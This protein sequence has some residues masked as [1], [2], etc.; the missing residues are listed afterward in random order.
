MGRGWC[1][2]DDQGRPLR[3]GTST[4]T[5]KHEKEPAGR[6]SEEIASQAEGIA[7]AE[8]GPSWGF[9][10]GIK[11]LRAWAHRVWEV[12]VREEGGVSPG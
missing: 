8:T 3:G 9:G 2:W 11:D 4:L 5:P 1:S 6:T 7:G 12:W 10:E